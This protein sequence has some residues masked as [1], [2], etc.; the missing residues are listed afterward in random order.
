MA[1][2]FDNKDN[3]YLPII[4]RISVGVYVIAAFM[5]IF[6]TTYSATYAE[7]GTATPLESTNDSPVLLPDV[8]PDKNTLMDYDIVK[9]PTN[10]DHFL[11]RFSVGIANYGPGRLEIVGIRDSVN[12]PIDVNNDKMPAY[13]RIYREDG[14]LYE[15]VPVGTLVYH[16]AHH[17]FHFYGEAKYSL[18]DEASGQTIMT[19]DKVSFCL[20]DVNIVDSSAK[21]FSNNPVYNSCAH[22][23]GAKFVKMGISSGWEDIY[24]KDL[25]GQA[26]DV[27]DLMS[28][29]PPNN[30]ILQVTTNPSALLKDVNNGKPQTISIG[31][32]KIGQGVQAGVGTSRPGV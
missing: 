22:D 16:P 13:Q 27:T 14:T 26:F 23:P 3:K 11:L 29:N 31:P 21:D 5:I 2:I 9:D 8:R 20:A 17:H 24:G 28:A 15:Q 32:I 18:I 1:G 25:V 6:P 19:S 4:E 7:N 12:S 30:Y 10:A